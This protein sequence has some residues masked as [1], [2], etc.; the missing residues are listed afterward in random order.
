MEMTIQLDVCDSED[1]LM[2]P[3]ATPFGEV[4]VKLIEEHGP[5]GG[6]PIYSFTG[7]AGAVFFWV[8]THYTD[9]AAIPGRADTE[10]IERVFKGAVNDALYYLFGEDTYKI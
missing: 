2:A 5:A 6:N 4:E 3:V 8:L 9:P 10:R 7:E 1:L